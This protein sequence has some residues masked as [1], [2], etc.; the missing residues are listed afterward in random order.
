[1]T[2]R[3]GEVVQLVTEGVTEREGD[4]SVENVE[5]GKRGRD[6]EEGGRVEKD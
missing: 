3:R 2:G 5:L 1:M 6:V 4:R